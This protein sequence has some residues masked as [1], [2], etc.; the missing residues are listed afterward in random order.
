MHKTNAGK[1]GLT[2]ADISS[3]SIGDFL[4]IDKLVN[5]Y[6][7]RITV[8]VHRLKPYAMIRKA[9]QQGEIE[10][11]QDK[12]YE[13]F[14]LIDDSKNELMI[15]TGRVNRLKQDDAFA[16]LSHD[17]KV[18]EENKISIATLYCCHEI[19]KQLVNYFPTVNFKVSS[20]SVEDQLI[21]NL[22]DKYEQISEMSR[23]G[24]AV[25]YRGKEVYTGRN[26]V[27]RVYRD[28]NMGDGSGKIN[29]PRL[30]RALNLKHRNVIKVLGSDLKN[31]PRH[32]V[33][34]HIDGIS[35]DHLIGHIPFTLHRAYKI[36]SQLCQAL[37]HL[38]ING[39]IH[40]NIKPDK[41]LID[42]ELEPVISPFEILSSSQSHE[43]NSANSQNLL[44]AAPELLNG[45]LQV[46][47]Y[48]T[49]QFAMGLLAFELIAGRPLFCD[50]AKGESRSNIQ[51]I[52]EKRQR[53]FFV[54]SYRKEALS[55]LQIPRKM[56][57]II[58]R[59]LSE[60][61]E[62]RYDS[63][64]EVLAELALVQIPLDAVTEVAM[65]SYERCCIANPNFTQSFYE[66][67]FNKSPERQEILSFFERQGRPD[68]KNRREK[69]LRVA[70]DLLI[71]GRKEPEKLSSIVRMDAHGG[72]PARLYQTFIDSMVETIAEN[73]YL[74][75]RYRD[76]HRLNPIEKA[77]QEIK[78]SALE[79]LEKPKIR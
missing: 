19:E 31:Y 49:D 3:H 9:L 33:L 48:K 32:L 27:I 62:N 40:G 26:V 34:E 47:D 75:R 4:N 64:K 56:E 66:H 16:V 15:Q 79:I 55:A 58:A 44:Y 41:V 21:F 2:V 5:D 10:E 68:V 59:M 12:L 61:P 69:M 43:H 74:W 54:K 71:R 13:F 35:L 65:S 6:G 14:R 37:Y 8:N 46:A 57:Q 39:I 60:K 25:F 78:T 53:F 30:A 29:D 77:W 20:E 24:S 36:I 67:L 50:L 63:M 70:I 11:A 28:L 45:T 1:F 52:F 23:G 18:R 72:I 42:N 73:D 22:M 76:E 7:E 51:A 38:H 17:E